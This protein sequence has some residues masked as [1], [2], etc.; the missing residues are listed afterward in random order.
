MEHNEGGD[1]FVS[2]VKREFSMDQMCVSK[3][4]CNTYAYI[5]IIISELGVN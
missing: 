2:S 5:D 1:C 4:I 3:N